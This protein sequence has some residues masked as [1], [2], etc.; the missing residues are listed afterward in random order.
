MHIFQKKL[1]QINATITKLRECRDEYQSQVQ[2]DID[3]FQ[4]LRRNWD[5]LRAQLRKIEQK[6]Q[7]L[8]D[9]IE[10]RLSSRLVYNSEDEKLN[11]NDDLYDDLA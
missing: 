6:N 8:K 5:K 7:T 9:N 11:I 1:D 3:A 2:E 4:D 10:A